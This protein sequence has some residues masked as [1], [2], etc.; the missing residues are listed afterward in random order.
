MTM[1][2]ILPSGPRESEIWVITY[3][4]GIYEPRVSCLRT[5]ALSLVSIEIPPT[6]RLYIPTMSDFYHP[7]YDSR[8]PQHQ[9][10]PMIPSATPSN[11]SD[12]NNDQPTTPPKS[13]DLH[14]QKSDAKPQA[15]FLTKLYA[16]VSHTTLFWSFSHPSKSSRAS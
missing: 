13:A 6:V 14:Q 15:T 5:S 8:Y 4:C 10:P 1:G 9:Y 11:S 2:R 7:S 12:E 3:K 16:Y